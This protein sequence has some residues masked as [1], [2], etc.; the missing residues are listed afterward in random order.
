MI[1][2]DRGRAVLLIHGC[3]VILLDP[4]EKIEELLSHYG[5]PLTALKGVLLTNSRNLN[6]FECLMKMPNLQLIA[7]ESIFTEVIARMKAYFLWTSEML[8]QKVKAKV[9]S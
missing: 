9:L 1:V 2:T 8:K 4:S 3:D 5:I 7:E 6:W